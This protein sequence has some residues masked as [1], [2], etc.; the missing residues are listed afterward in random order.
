ME[1]LFEFM[2]VGNVVRVAAID[3]VS[4]TEVVMVGSPRYSRELL[5]KMA[6]RKLIYVMEKN[7]ATGIMGS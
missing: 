4:R 6:A 3:P 1:V 7:R 5:K 2:R